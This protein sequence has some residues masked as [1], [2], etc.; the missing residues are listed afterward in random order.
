MQPH[1]LVTGAPDD[2]PSSSTFSKK[3]SASGSSEKASN[4]YPGKVGHLNVPSWKT[5]RRPSFLPNDTEMNLRPKMRKLST[6]NVSTNDTINT[7]SVGSNTNVVVEDLVDNDP[8]PC[9]ECI[10]Q[11]VLGDVQY[12]TDYLDRWP[13]F[14]YVLPLRMV[15][16]LLRTLGA[17]ILANNPFSGAL[18]LLALLL[19][20]PLV[21][22]WGLGALLVA[23]VM[24]L[25][26]KQPQHII[27]S[28]QVTQHSLLLGILVGH[29]A[30]HHHDHTLASA[31]VTLAL[32]AALSVVLG[33]AVSTWFSQ[34]NLP[35][36][37]V[38]FVV[39]GATLT[40]GL[41][42]QD[43]A[44]TALVASTDLTNASTFANTDLQWSRV[45]E[46]VA[47]G[48]GQVYGCTSVVSSLL[49]L[50]AMMVFS[51]LAFLQGLMGAFL[52]ALSG[53]LVSQPP[54]LEVYAGGYG[55]HSLLTA[56]SLG[57]YYFVVNFYS[58]LTAASGAVLSA[59]LF[60]AFKQSSMPVLT[61]PHVM[62]T[63]VLLH[64]RVRGGQLKRVDLIY[65]TFPE[66]HRRLFRPGN[67][68]EDC[69]VT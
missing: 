30:Q 5:A 62:A 16:A 59:L 44:S 31:V 48:A 12:I 50:A 39:L 41:G 6:Y 60:R 1:I 13:L 26:L 20:A 9:L 21:A 36:L 25:V 69:A 33:I 18:V 22:L 65:L 58:T 49:V 14:S 38:S 28:G 32:T 51:P 61:A 46:G 52:G 43:F 37:T 56:L 68:V 54:Y 29:S 15:N 45:L 35:G 63:L 19:E 53:V 3:T 8:P 11:W 42:Y 57:G 23:L 17:P 27:S 67:A 64:A 2:T 47:R 34:T 7:D 4:G 66:M 24:A 10:T 55:R 40:C